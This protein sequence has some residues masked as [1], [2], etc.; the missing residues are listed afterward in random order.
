M[1]RR[2]RHL[3]H[4]TRT[5]SLLFFF[6]CSFRSELADGMLS[7]ISSIPD[8]SILA[9]VGERMQQR[10]GVSSGLFTSLTRARVNIIA[11]VQGSSEHNI[12]VVVSADSKSRALRAAHASFYLSDQTVSIGVIGTSV[13]GAAFLAQVKSQLK[14]LDVKFC[15]DLRARGIATS[16]QMMFGDPIDLDAWRD[17]FATQSMTMQTDLDKFADYIQDIALPHAVICYCTA[18]E[19]V[20]AYYERWLRR[21]IRII[22]PNKKANSG[23]LTYYNAMRAARGDDIPSNLYDTEPPRLRESSMFNSSPNPTGHGMFPWRTALMAVALFAIGITFL[24]A[25]TLHLARMTGTRK[26]CSLSWALSLSFRAAMPCST[27]CSGTEGFPI[28]TFLNVR[29]H[30]LLRF[31]YQSSVFRI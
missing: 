22:T 23:P 15:T 3:R 19:A 4:S 20:S 24:L 17:N 10:P 18:S 9:M 6:S 25:A 13:V 31:E 30:S 28:S 8:F 26:S 2:R 7:S 5:Y 21:G 29:F 16:R 1:S 12:S 14:T 27:L 11:M